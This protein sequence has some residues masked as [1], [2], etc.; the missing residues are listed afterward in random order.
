MRSVCIHFQLNQPSR[1]V[2]YRFF[3]INR[4]HD[5]FDEYQNRYLTTR[6]A[7]RCYLPA[8]NMLMRLIEK[9]GEKVAF[10]FSISGSSLSLFANN[11]PEV[12]DSF[13]TLTDTGRIEMTGNTFS[14]S[15][16]S[17]YNKST[18]L[19]QI[20]LQ[21]EALEKHF[22]IRPLT[23]CNTEFIY[24][25]E[26]GEW[27]YDAGYKT[28][29]TEGAKHILGWKSPGFLYCNPFQTDLK[30][31]L[32]NYNICDDITY[33]FTDSSWDRYPLTA[34]KVLETLDQLPEDSPMVNLY[35]DYEIMGEF[36]TEETGIFQFFE[37]LFS[38][39]A[40]SDRYRFMRP[41]EILQQDLPVSTLHVPWPVSTSG[42]EKDTSRWLGN[43][44]QEEAF[45]QL[46]KL[47]DLYLASRNP[48]ARNHWVLMQ[49]AD[50]FNFMGNKW[51][52]EPA[53]YRNFEVYSSPYQAFIHYMNI[54]NDIKLQ[55]QN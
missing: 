54:V 3:D 23:F 15:I 11:Y 53:V 44:L 43:E 8:N 46:F 25:D 48:V 7:E 6:L 27:I 1:L 47:E 52:S 34:E 31:L 16:A 45:Y 39:I 4:K 10:S 37:T 14:H 50:Y 20:R 19:E 9:Y 30:L 40:E 33:R 42:E 24:S 49:E 32:R 28:V 17:L 12:L 51:I 2:N 35:F 21:E 29:L 41:D 13:K 22:G 36:Y 38:Y 5:Y 18:F 55:L 26:I